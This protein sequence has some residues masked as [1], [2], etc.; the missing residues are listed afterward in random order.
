MDSNEQIL[1]ILDSFSSFLNVKSVNHPAVIE[2][3]E[4]LSRLSSDESLPFTCIQH[5]FKN[6]AT[7]PMLNSF[8]SKIIEEIQSSIDHST[9]LLN[10]KISDIEEKCLGL[11]HRIESVK[12]KFGMDNDSQVRKFGE[13]QSFLSTKPW[14]KDMSS[15]S[16]E[17]NAKPNFEDLYSVKISIEPKLEEIQNISQSLQKNIKDFEGALARIDE[18]LLTKSSKD[19]IRYLNTQF[20]NYLSL[21][22]FDKVFPEINSRVFSLEQLEKNRN[23]NSLEFMN[24][25]V[26]HRTTSKD[27]S[28]MFNKLSALSSIVES[29]ADKVEIL[30]MLESI[31]LKDINFK[32]TFDSLLFDFQQIAGIQQECLKTMIRSLDSAEKKN[33]QR[34][35]LLK[36]SEKILAS[37]SFK[38]SENKNQIS[39][40]S[41]SFARNSQS[42]EIPERIIA[43]N[44]S[45][46]SNRTS[47][48]QVYNSKTNRMSLNN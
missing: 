42:P 46:N 4:F 1:E 33:K 36:A 18:I 5:I 43:T 14:L 12:K 31:E 2:L 8:K 13:I 7:L 10:S 20:D 25:K 47:K 27:F 35:D 37:I 28:T 19:D 21:S 26:S 24:D 44:L 38:I 6:L 39:S 15:L 29:K 3:S 9:L 11:E 48:R 41:A 22:Y 16:D 40:K 30:P 17:I 23:G 45:R 32:R 34:N